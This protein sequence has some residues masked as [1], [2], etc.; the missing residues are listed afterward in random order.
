MMRTLGP[1]AQQRGVALVLALI[2]LLVLILGAV[3]VMRSTSSALTSTANLAF[4]RDL[5]NQAEQAVAKAVAQTALPFAADS[6]L[7][8]SAITLAVN[9]Q[10]IPQAL[11]SDSAFNAV[12]RSSNDLTGVNK[13]KIRYVVERLCNVA[14]QRASSSHCVVFEQTPVGGSSHMSGNVTPDVQPVYRVT[15][16]VQGPRNTKVFVQSTFTKP[17]A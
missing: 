7:N 5:I 3:A 4:R 9:A 16:R 17:E 8:Y 1:S 14:N 11:L 6:S 10:G 15:V 12:G 13:V 2:V